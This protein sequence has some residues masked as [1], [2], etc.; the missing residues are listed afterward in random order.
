MPCTCTSNHE[1]KEKLLTG[2]IHVYWYC[3]LPGCCQSGLYELLDMC[4]HQFYIPLLAGDESLWT[5]VS[6]V[7]HEGGL[8]PLAIF[9]IQDVEDVTVFKGEAC[10]GAVVVFGGVVV[11]ESSVCVCMCWVGGIYH[12]H[13]H[14]YMDIRRKSLIRA[15]WDKRDERCSDKWI[16]E[17]TDCKV[18]YCTAKYL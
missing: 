13:I 1:C 18:D 7:P 6:V 3:Q 5:V 2:S 4:K 8:S 15:H 10:G 11:K 12:A 14:M 16:S 17:T 9:A